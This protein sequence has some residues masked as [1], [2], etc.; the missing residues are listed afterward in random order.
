MALAVILACTLFPSLVQSQ[1]RTQTPA[2]A[3][4][5][6]P[7][8]YI[9]EGGAGSLLLKPGKN[10]VLQFSIDAVGANGHTCSLEGDL[11]NGRAKLEAMEEKNPCIVTMTQTAEG[12]VVKGSESGA[13]SYYCGLR[14]TFEAVYF[15]PVPACTAKA[16]AAT[17]KSFKQLYDAKKFAEAR[18][19]LEP[20]LSDCSRS[21]YWMESGRIRNDLAVTLHKLGDVAGCQAVLQ[22]LADDAK[23]TD[24]ELQEKYPPTDL[25]SY[26]TVVR[27]TRTNLKL[28]RV[29]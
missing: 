8:E 21:L 11:I 28:C 13:C 22:T 29:K 17:R 26:M 10:G 15:Q 23:A 9:S 20:V 24:S 3:N 16:V 27:S 19:R 25:E 18:S 14:A 7:G 6:K 2:S 4:A 12:I 1:A 5:L